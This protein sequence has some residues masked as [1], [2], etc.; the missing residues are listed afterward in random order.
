MTGT[1][2]EK[3][4]LIGLDGGTFTIF[5][6]LIDEGVMPFLKE[7]LASSARADL[8]SVIPALTPPA[9]TSLMTGRHPGN[10]GVFDF[11]K[12]RITIIGYR[13]LGFTAIHGGGL[14]N[15]HPDP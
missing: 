6:A 4:V 3:T 14:R 2:T 9:W 1:A 5:D 15:T 8:L 10:H 12:G 11:F 7:F 13:Q